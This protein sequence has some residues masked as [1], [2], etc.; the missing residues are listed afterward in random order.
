MGVDR[1]QFIAILQK[2]FNQKKKKKKWKKK[3]YTCAIAP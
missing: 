1:M 3:R 2:D